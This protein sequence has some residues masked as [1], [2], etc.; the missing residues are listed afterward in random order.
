MIWYILLLIPI[1]ICIYISYEKK[2]LKE[3]KNLL[4][5]F[6]ELKKIIGLD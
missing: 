6:E 4:D 3:E 2:L 1:F 5:D